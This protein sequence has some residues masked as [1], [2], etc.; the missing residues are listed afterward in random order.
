MPSAPPA[1]VSPAAYADRLGAEIA[2]AVTASPAGPLPEI[3]AAAIA[4][5]V[6]A[7][8][9]PTMTGDRLGQLGLPQSRLYRPRY[10]SLARIAAASRELPR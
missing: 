2:S 8:D 7:L 3:L 6:S 9:L 10:L 5:T 1:T 4:A